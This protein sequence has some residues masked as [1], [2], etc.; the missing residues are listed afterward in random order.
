MLSAQGLGRRGS[1]QP[2]D[3]TMRSGEVLG[4][5]GLLGSGRTEAARLLF[6][7][8][9]ADSG[10]ARLDGSAAAARTAARGSDELASVSAPRNAR[11][12]ASSPNSAM[13]EN[14]VLA[15]QAKRGVF[16]HLEQETQSAMADELHQAAGHQDVSD[17]ESPIGQL[18]GGNQQKA[19][20]A[21]WL[22]T[23]P[24][25]ADPRRADARHR[26]RGQAGDHGSRARSSA[27]RGWRFSSSRR[28]CRRCCASATHRRAARPPARSAELPAGRR[29]G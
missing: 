2:L 16:R 5:A 23:E 4:L 19:M 28:R 11:P 27:A 21:R 6:G 12:R 14:I 17:A 1:L 22:A 13:R 9:R 26:R 8:D 18:S 29:C 15:L 24:K 3:L 10:D 25:P 7:A 20:L